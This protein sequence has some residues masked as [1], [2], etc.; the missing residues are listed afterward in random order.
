MIIKKQILKPAN[1]DDFE[2]LCKRLWGELWNCS[3]RIKGMVGKA[4][5]NMALT[6]MP[7]VFLI[8]VTVEFNVKEKMNI[9]MRNSQRLK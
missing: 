1:W 7:I 9:L 5:L 6:S 8:M 4:K 2:H 3:D